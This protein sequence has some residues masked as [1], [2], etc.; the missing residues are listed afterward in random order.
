[1]IYGRVIYAR[2]AKWYVIGRK[3][4]QW[5]GVSGV[6]LRSFEGIHVVCDPRT[7]EVI[8]AFRNRRLEAIRVI[9]RTPKWRRPKADYL[10]AA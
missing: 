5:C 6:E 1:M 7:E 4:A 3:E 8:T 2:H 10:P 9:R